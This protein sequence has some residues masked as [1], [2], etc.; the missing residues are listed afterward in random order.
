MTMRGSFSWF[1]GLSTMAGVLQGCEESRACLLYACHTSASVSSKV[2]R[3]VESAK[4]EVRSCHGDRC[5]D[6]VLVWTE[7]ET[8]V[9]LDEGLTDD[10]HSCVERT[11]DSLEFVTY[12]TFDE[13]VPSEKTFSLRVVD[14][15]SGDVL[16]EDAGE[17]Q[18][19]KGP[20]WDHC[21]DCWNAN[22]ELSARGVGGP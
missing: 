2:A 18:F 12:W 11:G 1:V 6:G 21:H 14:R 22:L 15:E 9:C 17:A 7:R 13:G 3:D 5:V 4:F 10:A 19:T 20:M 16:V 8:L